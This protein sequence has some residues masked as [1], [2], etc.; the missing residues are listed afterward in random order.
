MTPR[1]DVVELTAGMPEQR[2]APG[3]PLFGQ[4]DDAG[5][6]VGVLVDGL[7]HVELD[8]IIIDRLTTSGAFVGEIGALLGTARTATVVAASPSTV[9]LIGDPESFFATHPGLALELARQLA[10][11]LQR[12]LAYLA[13]VRAQYADAEGHLGMVDAVLGRLSARPPIDIE[14]GSDRSPDY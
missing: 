14:P 9:R 8:G 13:D 1:A 10:G 7:L 3:E 5:R 2:L 12:I 11:R 4:G 6:V